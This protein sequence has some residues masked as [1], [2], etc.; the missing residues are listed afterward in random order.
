MSTFQNILVPTDFSEPAERAAQFAAVF[1]EK[2]DAKLTLL[3]VWETPSTY[4][5]GQGLDWPTEEL[6]RQAQKS[7]DVAL[8]KLREALPRAQG[9]V[10]PGV[11]LERILAEAKDMNADLIV[12]GT[13]GRRGLSH[14]FLGS[15][16]ERVVRR[17]PI[18]VLTVGPTPKK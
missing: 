5:Y 10:V 7:L 16:A 6:A 8:A 14:V 15:V 18:P 9:R 12:M 17:S 13:H 1:A 11:A 4:D 2:F 3:H